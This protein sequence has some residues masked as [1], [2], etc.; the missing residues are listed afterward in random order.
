[1]NVVCSHFFYRTNL[2]NHSSYFLFA[3][4]ARVLCMCCVLFNIL[5]LCVFLSIT[6]VYLCIVHFTGV[7]S[8]PNILHIDFIF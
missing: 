8:I 1:M 3:Q 5:F 6:V 7:L 4:D 2:P